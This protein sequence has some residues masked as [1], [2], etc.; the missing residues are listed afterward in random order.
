MSCD[1]RGGSLAVD[2][3]TQLVGTLILLVVGVSGMGSAAAS[4]GAQQATDSNSIVPTAPPNGCSTQV[5]ALPSPQQ[6]SKAFGIMRSVDG[7]KTWMRVVGD[8]GSVRS[9][10]IDSRGRVFGGTVGDLT[11]AGIELGLLQSLDD[12]ETWIRTTG[13][14]NGTDLRDLRSIAVGANGTIYGGTG[15]G[16]VRSTDGGKTW[17]TANDGL[18]EGRE[19]NIQSIAMDA[20]GR[21]FAGTYD[22]VIRFSDASSKWVRV[23]LAGIPVTAIL[24]TP[25]GKIYAGTGGK[26]LYRSSNAG[27][28]W[29]PIDDGLIGT[30]ISEIAFAPRG[31]LYAAVQRSGVFRSIDGG[32][33]WKRTLSLG[34]ETVAYAVH[35]SAGGEIFA[36]AGACCPAPSVGLFRSTDGGNNWINLLNVTDDTAVGAISVSP[37]GTIMV[38]LA[39]VGE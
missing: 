24:V 22:G 35:V 29:Q 23:G 34:K 18:A 27:L 38:G 10:T 14:A 13:C 32:V 1:R 21:L 4:L 25:G 19:R 5:V 7:G 12:G 20:E 8:S 9:L 33:T 17:D 11:G 15:S 2:A 30:W 6:S 39:W 26:G 37:T 16:L 28:S 3:A 31:N 36:S